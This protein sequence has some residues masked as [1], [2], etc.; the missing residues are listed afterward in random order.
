MSSWGVGNFESDDALDHV[1]RMLNSIA[2]RVEKTVSKLPRQ[3][4][5]DLVPLLADMELLGVIARHVY[6]SATMTW[7]IRGQL[8]PDHLEIR[9]WKVIVL[10]AFDRIPQ[11]NEAEK[12]AEIQARHRRAIA[13]TFD[14]LDRLSR[15]QIFGAMRTCDAYMRELYGKGYGMSKS[16]IEEYEKNMIQMERELMEQA[17]LSG[18]VK[19][20]DRRRKKG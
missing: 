6:K 7:V 15:R 20:V 1:Y 4:H 14:K 2:E 19:A 13:A 11:E 5:F 10:Q 8:L 16:C 12:S 3:K 17:K 9:K 18:E